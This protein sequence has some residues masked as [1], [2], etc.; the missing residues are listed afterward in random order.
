MKET[1]KL[2]TGLP[3]DFWDSE[4]NARRKRAITLTRKLNAMDPND[5]AAKVPVIRELFGSVGSDPCVDP[6]FNCDNG[7]NIYVGDE[8]IA[9]YNVTILDIAPVHIGDHAM[10]GP[11]SK[12]ITVGH[13]LSPKERRK[14]IGIAKPVRIGDDFWMG[15]GAI[16][17]P[18]VTI[19]NNVVV[20]AGAVVTKDVPDNCVI[21]GVPAK[22]IRYTENDIE[23]E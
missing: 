18:G 1:E 23:E 9:N 8:F 3:Y 12:I 20:A 16:I 2:D 14:H 13:P 7:L 10:L 6:V 22:I 15:A 17:L 5:E 4:V 21:A 19:G 11:G